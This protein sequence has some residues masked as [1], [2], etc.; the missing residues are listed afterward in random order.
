M[1]R[2]RQS[3]RRKQEEG[4]RKK[5]AGR[6]KKGGKRNG[7]ALSRGPFLVHP[8]F[9]LPPPLFRLTSA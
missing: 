3:G 4:S 5:E 1:V 7:A 6:R 9:L 2:E 8:L